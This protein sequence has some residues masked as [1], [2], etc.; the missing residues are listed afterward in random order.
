[1]VVVLVKSFR[2]V[3]LTLAENLV[4]L[5]KKHLDAFK[6][7]VC[8]EKHLVTEKLWPLVRVVLQSQEVESEKKFITILLKKVVTQVETILSGSSDC[9]Q[10]LLEM[11]SLL[12]QYSKSDKQLELWKKANGNK[13]DSVED[14]LNASASAILLKYRMLITVQKISGGCDSRLMRSLR[15]GPKLQFKTSQ[16]EIP[17]SGT[18]QGFCWR[19]NQ[20]P[21]F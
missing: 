6:L 11:V 19:R 14:G 21:K 9:E 7:W 3:Y 16:G 20:T 18:K 15:S 10:E 4:K 2:P 8:Q 12:S 13:I 1:L 17:T 5:D